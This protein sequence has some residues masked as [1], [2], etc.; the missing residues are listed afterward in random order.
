[1]HYTH[2]IISRKLRRIARLLRYADFAA[3]KLGIEKAITDIEKYS[4]ILNSFEKILNEQQMK[5]LS[6]I[7]TSTKTIT[8]NMLF[9]TLFKQFKE[10]Y[11]KA[12][13]VLKQAN[14]MR[15]VNDMKTVFQ[16][17]MKPLEDILEIMKKIKSHF[18]D[19]NVKVPF[20]RRDRQI[21]S[22]YLEY[23]NFVYH[24]NQAIDATE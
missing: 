13:Q 7:W 11:P 6:N 2:S 5:S 24:V 19:P 9:L 21:Q 14:T 4:G 20:D 12:M 17:Q 10:L 18:D 8:N 22:G 1:M 3:A 15:S 16:E 23:Q